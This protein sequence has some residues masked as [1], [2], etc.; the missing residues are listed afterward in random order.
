MSK[1]AFEIGEYKI[2]IEGY[3]FV[4]IS[5]SEF[6]KANKEG[7]IYHSAKAYAGIEDYLKAEELFKK[8]ISEYPN[9]DLVTY[10][11]ERLII[12]QQKLGR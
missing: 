2:A 1:C 3:S 11:K 8:V 10:A 7:I 4:E 12:V 9:S 5:Q 6:A